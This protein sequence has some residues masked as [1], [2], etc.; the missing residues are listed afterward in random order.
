MFIDNEL[1][2]KELLS[3]IKKQENGNY[4]LRMF[5]NCIVTF[6]K[7]YKTMRAAKM[8]QTK[9]LFKYFREH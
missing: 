2:T 8:V 5:E 3:M 1:I 7:E 4:K 6:E 9:L